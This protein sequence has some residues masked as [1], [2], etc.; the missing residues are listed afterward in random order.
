MSR[1]EYAEVLR[2]IWFVY[3]T[4][5]YQTVTSLVV[6]AAS[7]SSLAY[8]GLAVAAVSA[9]LLFRM[10]ELVSTLL[11][12]YT[13]S[14]PFLYYFLAL[15]QRWFAEFLAIS[16]IIYVIAIHLLAKAIKP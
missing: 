9:A 13:F 14:S 15:P 12:L 6:L 11:I 5:I 10:P 2:F 16:F 4:A 8:A 3:I 1:E 7:G